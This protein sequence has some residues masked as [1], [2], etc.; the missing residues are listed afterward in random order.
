LTGYG[1]AIQ[2]SPA[3]YVNRKALELRSWLIDQ[4]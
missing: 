2:A 3:R 1:Y 4:A